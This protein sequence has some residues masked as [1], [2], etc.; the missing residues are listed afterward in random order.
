MSNIVYVKVD[1]NNKI[2]AVDSSYFLQDTTGW[3]EIDRGEGVEYRFAQGNYLPLP[4]YTYNGIPRYKLVDGKPVERTEDEINAD[5][6]ELLA[7]ALTLDERVETLE[8]DTA[9]LHE[10]LDM[11]LTGVTE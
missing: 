10:A 9:E 8:G 5:Q 4:I 11:I 7:P 3:I 1:D 6:G 2:I